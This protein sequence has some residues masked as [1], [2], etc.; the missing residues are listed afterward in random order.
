MQSPATPPTHGRSPRAV[1]KSTRPSVSPMAYPQPGSYDHMLPQSMSPANL[2]PPPSSY[3]P[4]QSF[5]STAH[6][7]M[8]SPMGYPSPLGTASPSQ[9]TSYT[10][11]FPSSGY[12]PSQPMSYS[13]SQQS[14]HSA[15]PLQSDTEAE[16]E[17]ETDFESLSFAVDLDLD[18]ESGKPTTSKAAPAS[19]SPKSVVSIPRPANA[20]ILYRSDRLKDI[21]AGRKIK[22]LDEVMRESGYSASSASA[23]SGDESGLDRM[24]QTTPA[25]SAS[26]TDDDQS[27]P[28]V[29][30]VRKA[31]KGAK[32]PTEGLLSLGRGK[33]GRGLPQAHISKMISILW[34][35]ESAEVRS[36]YEQLSEQ[37]K[38]EVSSSHICVMM[39]RRN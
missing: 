16:A 21:S 34:K 31:K 13:L 25:T 12:F 14:G 39:R 27:K 3:T 35:R 9:F 29:K 38:Q 36:K 10:G 17:G 32:E 6:G 26:V 15:R 33:T 30:K 22:G 5:G 4:G 11:S 23:S 28:K 19:K 24:A 2:M 18:L 37:R 20:W 1:R 8:A 7:L